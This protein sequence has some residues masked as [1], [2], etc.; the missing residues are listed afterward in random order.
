VPALLLITDQKEFGDITLNISRIGAQK[1][2]SDESK[3]PLAVISKITKRYNFGLSISDKDIA[4][5]E[6][7]KDFLRETKVLKKEFEISEL[8]DLS[9]LKRT[10]IK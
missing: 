10:G 3:F 1:A 6:Q 8:F 2:I 7:V 4:A 5:L 9:Y